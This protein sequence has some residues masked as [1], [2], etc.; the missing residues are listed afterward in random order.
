MDKWSDKQNGK[1]KYKNIH[2]E[3]NFYN[4][5]VHVLPKLKIFHSSNFPLEKKKSLLWSCN[6]ITTASTP[7]LE[8]ESFIEVQKDK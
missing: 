2:K 5:I 6:N 4:F 8:K 7:C 1:S 3:I